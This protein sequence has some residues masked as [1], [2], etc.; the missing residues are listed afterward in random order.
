MTT[1]TTTRSRRA[2]SQYL[3]SLWSTTGHLMLCAAY[4]QGAMTKLLNFEDAI[5]EMRHF[6][7]RPE[8]P[9][10]V[11]LILFEITASAM[12]ISGC[13]RWIGAGALCMF[14]VL[15]SFIALRFWELPAGMQQTMAMNAFF[16]HVGLAGAFLLLAGHDLAKRWQTGARWTR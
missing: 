10:A 13:F 3:R 16:E 5:Q 2:P 7:L 15:A 9:L 12:V 1:I 6:G 14:T 11:A 4:L 8:A